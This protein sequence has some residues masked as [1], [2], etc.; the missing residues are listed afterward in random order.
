MIKCKIYRWKYTPCV[1][2][3]N[4][5]KNHILFK[6][7]ST[8]DK[9]YFLTKTHMDDSIECGILKDCQTRCIN[10]GIDINWFDSYKN[11]NNI[12]DNFIII[13]TGVEN[14]DLETLCKSV[15]GTSLFLHIITKK[16]YLDLDNLVIL[17][18]YM[19]VSNIQIDFAEDLM[20]KKIDVLDY[21]QKSV[22]SSKCVAVCTK[23]VNY[24]VG[25]TQVV[26]SLPFGIP[27]LETCNKANPIDVEKFNIGF[28]MPIGNVELWK[29]KFIL[30][31]SNKEIYEE[32]GKNARRLALKEF[33]GIDVAK[34][35]YNDIHRIYY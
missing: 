14:R 19:E 3:N 8:F 16:K 20:K 1:K 26:E 27:I 9:V 33:N 17:N 10:Y 30:L 11:N 5:I 28:N 21:I 13:S 22:A 31:M 7:Y 24:G 32:Y 4:K 18:P 2:S 12:S 23:Q 34:L 15:I 6:Y 25:Y 29:Q 35:I